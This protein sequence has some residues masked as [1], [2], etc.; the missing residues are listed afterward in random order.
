[1]QS[2]FSGREEKFRQSF[3]VHQAENCKG[4]TILAKGKPKISASQGPK[5]GCQ[6]T[7]RRSIFIWYTLWSFIHSCLKISLTF[8][9]K[10]RSSYVNKGKEP[11]KT[12]CPL[13]W[14]FICCIKY[15]IDV[16]F[17][18]IKSRAV[19]KQP[20]ENYIKIWSFGWLS[21][22]VSS[23][24]ETKIVLFLHVPSFFPLFGILIKQ[25]RNNVELT[26]KPFDF[27]CL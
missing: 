13:W 24:L 27:G 8:S 18:A 14:I 3:S 12:F 2:R 1:M 4:A 26:L 25:T 20:L 9:P 15:L 22:N 17:L 16:I 11:I 6:R 21:L 5:F 23:S 7:Q 19:G 10:K